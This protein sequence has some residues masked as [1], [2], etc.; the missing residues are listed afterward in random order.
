MNI[1]SRIQRQ[2]I[3]VVRGCK[4]YLLFHRLET[5]FSHT[6]GPTLFPFLSSKAN[7]SLQKHAAYTHP[8]VTA[9]R[10]RAKSAWPPAGRAEPTV[11]PLSPLSRSLRQR[12]EGASPSLRCG[13]LPLS[14]SSLFPGGG[15]G[16]TG[17][18]SLSLRRNKREKILIPSF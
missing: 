14:T 17:G 15:G 6:F 10:E 9:A 16:G 1:F 11:Q 3:W 12:K 5:L 2:Q 7:Q 18:A 13:A 8:P 4:K